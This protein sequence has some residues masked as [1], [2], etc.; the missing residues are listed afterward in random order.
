MKRV[1]NYVLPALLLAVAG[2]TVCIPESQARTFTENVEYAVITPPLGTQVE[3]GQVEVAEVFWYGCPHCYSLE[4]TI[5]EYLKTKPENVTFSRVP[6]MLD[7]KWSFHGKLYYVGQML[8]ADGSKDVHAKIFEA[9]QKQ[10]RRIGN[11]DQLRRFYQ[12]IG[13]K[14]D[15]I[16]NAL[17]SLELK[18]KLEYAKGITFDSRLDSVPT[19]IV[20]GKYLTSPSMVAGNDKLIEVINYLTALESK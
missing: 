20:N 9:L 5:E 2:L 7:A 4:P 10:R 1:F 15:E 12:G 11:D 14:I 13:F 6:A 18:T 17:K 19:V 16:N 3:E 8:D